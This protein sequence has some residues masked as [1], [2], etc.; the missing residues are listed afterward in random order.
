M[1]DDEQKPD[2]TPE[3][4]ESA[5]KDEPAADDAPVAEEDRFRPG[6][7]AARIDTLGEESDIERIAREEETKLRERKKGKK[8]KR[9][10]EAAASKRLAKIGEVKVK[11]PSAMGDAVTSSDADPLLLR[12]AR[13][14]EW[15]KNHQQVF[16]GVVAIAAIGLL[17]FLGYTYWQGKHDADASALL[18]QAYADDNGRVSDKDD[19][20]D[21]EGKSLPL[22]PTFKTP[23]ARRDAAL[24]KYRQV[25][26]KYSGTGAATLARLAE[27][28]LLLDS[29]DSKGASD[30]YAEVKGSP[31]AQADAE[32]RG[33]AIEGIGFAAELLAQKE[34]AAKAAHLDAAL[35]AF[36]QLEQVD[37]MGFKELG[38][39][40]EARVALEK[41]DKAQAIDLL[42]DVYHRVTE[43]GE[44][45]AFSYLE[46]VVEDRLRELDPTA[47]P[48][49]TPKLGGPGGNI[50]M[51]DPRIQQLIKQLQQQQQQQGGGAPP[52]G[53]PQ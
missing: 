36:K 40:H 7:I 20:D 24:A 17:G 31:L 53:A 21:T 50:D 30:V 1:P 23:V 11:R 34:P 43:P 49:K 26:S 9:G 3:D 8:G 29:G 28:G 52:P 16:G 41:G 10:L 22:Y 14:T 27:A 51:N 15:I 32:V 25:E 12:T 35:A 6:A 44:D 4:A 45:H 5:P 13:L 37:T 2:P 39:Y 33:R 19:D 18:A 42:K 38:M 48:P 46:F 47:L